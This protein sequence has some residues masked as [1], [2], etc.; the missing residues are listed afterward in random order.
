MA[1]RSSRSRPSA[2]SAP[3]KRATLSA[4]SAHVNCRASEMNAVSFDLS[5]A[6]RRNAC[7]MYIAIPRLL[8]ILLWFS[9]F[10][11]PAYPVVDLGQVGWRGCGNRRPAAVG[12]WPQR[13]WS[14][15][16]NRPHLAVARR[17][18]L[19]GRGV[20]AFQAAANENFTQRPKETVMRDEHRHFVAWS[21]VEPGTEY[22]AAALQSFLPVF[23]I[24]RQ[25]RAGRF[26]RATGRARA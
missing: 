16:G 1:T 21:V 10:A 20:S 22:R 8:R 2:C 15:L 3:A 6:H 5:L 18:E 4:S 11:R 13:L 26:A 7:V 17:H 19:I 25:D 23:R 24:R 12:P 9:L 14:D